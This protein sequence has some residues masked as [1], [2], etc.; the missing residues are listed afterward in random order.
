MCQA[1]CKMYLLLHYSLLTC[2]YCFCSFQRHAASPNWLVIKLNDQYNTFMYYIHLASGFSSCELWIQMMN[3]NSITH[4]CI[5]FTL[6]M[7]FYSLSYECRCWILPDIPLKASDTWTRIGAYYQQKCGNL[8]ICMKNLLLFFK[9]VHVLDCT[10][11]CYMCENFS[12][13]QCHATRSLWLLWQICSVLLLLAG[14]Y[15]VETT[16]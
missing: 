1:R 15:C 5:I 11:S 3:I 12:T 16:G 7:G 2:R 4:S 8:P 6:L 9:I 14:R 10:K 13:L